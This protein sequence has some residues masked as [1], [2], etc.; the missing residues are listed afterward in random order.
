L[1]NFI[2]RKTLAANPFVLYT[3]LQNPPYA[4]YQD[5]VGS[6]LWSRDRDARLRDDIPGKNFDDRLPSAF[7]TLSA[8]ASLD[9]T[10]IQYKAVFEPLD[11][12]GFLRP[13]STEV[14]W[15]G[16]FTVGSRRFCDVQFTYQMDM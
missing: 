12:D 1:T 15:E 2:L 5:D 13:G 6:S 8:E 14:N 7:W 4:L 16:Y 9:P 11:S 3:L 10:M